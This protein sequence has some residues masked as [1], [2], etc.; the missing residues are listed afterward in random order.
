MCQHVQVKQRA[1]LVCRQRRHPACPW[2]LLA[3]AVPDWRR[4]RRLQ[5][6]ALLQRQPPPPLPRSCA[7]VCSCPP[8]CTC[9]Q[10]LSGSIPQCRRRRRLQ[11]QALF[12]RRVGKP[13]AGKEAAARTVIPGEDVEVKADGTVAPAPRNG[14]SNNGAGV[15]IDP[16]TGDV[17]GTGGEERPPPGSGKSGG[18]LAGSLAG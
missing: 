4:H 5:C 7:P 18:A 2:C 8:V 3:Q 11:C 14:A 15:P 13:T 1:P 17:N 16:L 10:K 9:W 12:N 6:H